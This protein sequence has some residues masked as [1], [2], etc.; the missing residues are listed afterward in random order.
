MEY[1]TS[2]RTFY[3]VNMAGRYRDYYVRGQIITTN[4]YVDVCAITKMMPLNSS[5]DLP[6][7]FIKL[8]QSEVTRF[9]NE[10]TICIN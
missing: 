10:I 7:D 1:G 2:K 8:S 3:R 4:T 6:E 5:S 9:S